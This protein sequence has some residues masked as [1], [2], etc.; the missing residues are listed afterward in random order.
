M[1]ENVEPL[2]ELASEGLMLIDKPVGPTSHDMVNWMRRHTGTRKVGHTG[3]LDP[4]ASGLLIMLIGRKY[5][6]L[7]DLY[8]KQDK[9]YECTALLGVETDTYDM[10]GEVLSEAPKEKVMAIGRADI[11]AA[12]ENFRG[13][14]QQTAPAFS[15]IKRQ[16]KKLYELARKGTLDHSTLPVRSVEIYNLKLDSFEKNQDSGEA[17]F[18]FTVHCSSGTYIRSLVHDI[19][20]ILG[21]GAAI[22]HLRRTKIGK[23]DVKNAL[24][25]PIFHPN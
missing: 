24:I 21:T 11:E 15:A 17:S 2:T 16:G 12:L 14:I 10:E 23:L 6:K 19:G 22:S 13:P 5:T 25:C 9:E 1:Q 3:T 18:S 4:M 8:L 20:E 7:Q